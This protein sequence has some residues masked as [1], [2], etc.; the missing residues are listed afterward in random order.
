MDRYPQRASL[1]PLRVLPLSLRARCR[2]SSDRFG[3]GLAF[4]GRR[5]PGPDQAGGFR[6]LC[7]PPALG[8]HAP[9]GERQLRQRD[10][11]HESSAAVARAK[12]GRQDASAAGFTVAER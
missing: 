12:G 10:H 4:D 9:G 7:R 5:Q 2:A 8:R 11:Q 6:E 3:S 1:L